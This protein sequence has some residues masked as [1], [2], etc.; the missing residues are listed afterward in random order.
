M[1]VS[2]D[3]DAIS[4]NLQLLHPTHRLSAEAEADTAHRRIRRSGGV[5]EDVQV[6]LDTSNRQFHIT[7]KPNKELLAPN[8]EVSFA[9]GES[10]RNKT[11][12]SEGQA[13][14]DVSG[15]VGFLGKFFHGCFM[16]GQLRN[17]AASLAA[18]NVCD[19]LVRDLA[20]LFSVLVIR[21]VTA[22]LKDKGP[23]VFFYSAEQ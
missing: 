20:L 17:D 15:D 13:E 16:T 8:M 2:E 19:G 1:I 11:R 10:R 4:H 23:K 18:I 22:G 3:G 5:V 12:N 14:E 6:R 9:A 21:L 7:L